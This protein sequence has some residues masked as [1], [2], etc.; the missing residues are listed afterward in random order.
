VAERCELT[1]LYTDQCAHC[2]GHPDPVA[3]EPEPHRYSVDIDN[4]RATTAQ[5]RSDC[6]DCNEP[7]NVGDPIT[8]IGNAYWVCAGCGS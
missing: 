4:P 2:L 7:I 3:V 8:L 5:W 6:P 1:E